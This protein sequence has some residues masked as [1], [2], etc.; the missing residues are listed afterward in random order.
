VLP[1]ARSGSSCF[2]RPLGMRQ[3]EAGVKVV[4]ERA[5]VVVVEEEEEEG[6]E[7][8]VVMEEEG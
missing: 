3:V 7:E 6:E 4:G 1:R 5:G 2:S 8:V